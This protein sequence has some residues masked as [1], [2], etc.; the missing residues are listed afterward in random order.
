M[1]IGLHSLSFPWERHGTVVSSWFALE[2]SGRAVVFCRLGLGGSGGGA[3]LPSCCIS[4][5][6]D[7]CGNKRISSSRNC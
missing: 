1:V 5:F 3:S 2:V 7:S 4:I 6:S